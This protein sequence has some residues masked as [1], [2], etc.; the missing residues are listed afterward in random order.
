MVYQLAAFSK[1]ELDKIKKTPIPPK[2]IADASAAIAPETRTFAQCVEILEA[3]TNGFK[4][5]TSESACERD[6]MIVQIATAYGTIP[7]AGN[8][9]GSK[10]APAA[11]T[12]KAM[13]EA[14]DGIAA[15]IEFATGKNKKDLQE[16]ADG[17]AAAIEF[18]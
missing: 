17:I 7:S 5:D 14:L 1:A 8:A 11:P 15:A 6:A 18:M 4:T 10:A 16:A 2:A 9:T 12:K 3:E 13:Q